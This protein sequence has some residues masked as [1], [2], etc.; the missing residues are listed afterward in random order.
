MGKKRP[1]PREFARMLAGPYR[2]MF[3]FLKPHLGRFILAL[4]FGGLFGLISG[5]LPL[6]LN[7]VNSQVFP[8]GK[9]KVDML[10][11]AVNGTGTGINSVVLVC[12]VIPLIFVLR[13]LCDYLN[14]YYM[15]W[16]ALRVL[17]DIRCKLYTHILHQSLEFFNR[18]RSG[19]LISRVANDTRTAQVA[20][21]SISSDLIKQPLTVI[22]AFAVLLHLDWKFTIVSLF[23]FPISI[24]PIVYYG[25]KVRR[26]GKFEEERIGSMMSIL[27]ES[28]AGI[29]VIKAFARE[30]REAENF[31]SLS[32]EQFKS[33]IRVRKAIEIVSPMVEAVSAVG[34]GLA[35]FYVWYTHLSAAK[36]LALLAGIFMLYDPIKKLS[37]IHLVMQ[38]CFNATNNIFEVLKRQPAIQDA[39]GAIEIVGSEGDIRI[40]NVTFRYRPGL[41]SAVQNLS[42]HVE[43]G[44]YYALVGMSGAG[45]SSIL[46]LLLRFYEPESG[47][48]RLDGR[49]IKAIKQTSLREQI[50]MVSQETFLFHD[51]ILSNIR[52]GRLN[53]SKEEVID[54]AKQAYAHDFIM[55]QPHG[56]ETVIGDKGCLLSGGQQQ[57]VSIARAL[58]KNAPVLL[59]DE[60]MS[61]LDSEAER[62]IQAGLDR[63]SE[64]RT[65]IAIAHRLSTVLK[66][67]QIV[68]MDRGELKE[69]GTHRELLESSTIYRKLY[70][71]Q[72][73]VQA[74]EFAGVA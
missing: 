38:Q 9:N 30:K 22:S 33:G 62:E 57:R 59:L 72:F 34:V 16:V 8:Q 25:K 6:V 46:S 44:R 65:V 24:V 64:G 53:A 28:F 5:L 52:Y 19:N 39:P 7:F 12:S 3:P 63:L 10:N 11:D 23:L 36:F 55:N 42:L 45:K 70:D 50:G 35:L 58:L 61:A 18:E 68:V 14:S 17:A 31:E 37:R 51:S 60:A 15:A 48:I 56:Y 40:E 73:N 26:Q 21:T 69:I 13:S 47:F 1:S 2:E 74:E 66:A 29:R 71:L 32:N 67:D 49:D 41:P 54:A 4:V 27:Q 43:P 20:L